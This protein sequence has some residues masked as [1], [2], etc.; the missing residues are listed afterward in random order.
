MVTGA[1]RGAAAVHVN[2]AHSVPVFAG[3][4]KGLVVS[5]CAKAASLVKWVRSCYY[6]LAHLLIKL[7]VMID[8]ISV[9]LSYT[10]E[11]LE[12]VIAGGFVGMP[13]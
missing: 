6:W 4:L 10:A 5:S 1:T 2:R 11:V 9:G 8:N 12:W 3:E 7:N 13:W